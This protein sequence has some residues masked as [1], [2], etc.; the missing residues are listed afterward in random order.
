MLLNKSTADLPGPGNYN[1]DKTKAFGKG[2][3]AVSIR[4]KQ[5][6]LSRLMSPGPGA[7]ELSRTVIEERSKTYKI[8]T[9]RR[10]DIVS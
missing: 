2:S 9:S 7:Y 1:S 8:G 3:I 5:K 6:D 4:G 10:V